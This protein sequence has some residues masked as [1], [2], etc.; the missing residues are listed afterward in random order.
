MTQDVNTQYNEIMELERSVM[1]LHQLFE[2][3]QYV[4][5]CQSDKLNVIEYNIKQA[6]EYTHKG[7]E[8]LTDAVTSQIGIRKMQLAPGLLVENRSTE[9]ILVILSQLTPLHWD[10]I[11]PGQ[12]KRL[13]CGRVFFTVSADFYEEKKV[14]SIAGNVAR[15][16]G[17]TA[18]AVVAAVALPGVF[19]AGTAGL[20]AGSA[21]SGVTSV[22]S[23]REFGVYADGRTVVFSGRIN[24]ETKKYE[25][26]YDCEIPASQSKESNYLQST[27]SSSEKES[28]NLDT[29]S[30]S[31]S[32]TRKVSTSIMSTFGDLTTKTSSITSSM[33]SS[34]NSTFSRMK[35]FS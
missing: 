17:I 7:N 8:D 32:S 6:I 2:D 24:S 16:A 18:A 21:L 25:L 22:K 5:E 4:I 9:K 20:V 29:S 28:S 30:G 23:A 12:T 3:F 27:T 19:V 34:M 33:T 14:P 26:Y 15:V 1:E 10:E 31:Q 11:E 13:F 35:M